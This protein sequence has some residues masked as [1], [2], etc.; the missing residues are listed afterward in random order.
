MISATI[1]IVFLLSWF[2]EEMIQPK[3]AKTMNRL[4]YKDQQPMTNI[5]ILKP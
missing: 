2:L 5:Q 3:I 4:F 1:T